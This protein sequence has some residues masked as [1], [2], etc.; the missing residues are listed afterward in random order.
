MRATARSTDSWRATYT[1]L[2]PPAPSTLSMTYPASR[3][4]FAG[5]IGR[6]VSVISLELVH[7]E[8]AQLLIHHSN[9]LLLHGMKTLADRL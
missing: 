9:V 3:A 4:G 2:V 1:R 8:L 7:G 5:R 6:G